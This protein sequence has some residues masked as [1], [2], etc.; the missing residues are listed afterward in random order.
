MFVVACAS[1]WV[2][3]LGQLLGQD[4]LWR[5]MQA[6]ARYDAL[7]VKPPPGAPPVV[8]LEAANLALRIDCLRKHARD[9]Y[10]RGLKGG[11]PEQDVPAAFY[12]LLMSHDI[13]SA[14]Q[15][16]DHPAGLFESYW[17]QSR[18]LDDLA[19]VCKELG[20]YHDHPEARQ[21]QGHLNSARYKLRTIFR[22]ILQLTQ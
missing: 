4:P 14:V 5:V 9:L 1:V 6:A 10:Y 17:I 15:S 22:P 16:F 19:P 18:L 12:M 8:Q 21:L 11:D 13:M 2:A 3:G 7:L 20:N